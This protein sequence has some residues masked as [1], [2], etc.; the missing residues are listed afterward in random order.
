[1]VPTVLR[2]ILSKDRRICCANIARRA[3]G[4]I[5]DGTARYRRY[6][7]T[8]VDRKNVHSIYYMTVPRGTPIYSVDRDRR[9]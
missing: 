5:E 8:K 3:F 7:P 1:M 6:W 9:M 2:W 4:I